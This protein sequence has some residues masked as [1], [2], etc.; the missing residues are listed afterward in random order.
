MQ[1][2]IAGMAESGPAKVL[3][4][5]AHGD[6]ASGAPV[7][8]HL[9]DQLLLP[10]ALADGTSRMVTSAVTGHLLTNLT[11]LQTF[12]PVQATVE[13]VREGGTVVVTGSPL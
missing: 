9:A 12:L 7:D 6:H 3:V 4:T 2:A 5:H 10:M 1:V 8:P 13:R 11:V